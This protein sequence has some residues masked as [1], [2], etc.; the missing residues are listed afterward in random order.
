MRLVSQGGRQTDRQAVNQSVDRFMA[1][2]EGPGNVRLCNAVKEK[3][4][5]SN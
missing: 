2:R 5:V 1:S 4:V 3:C